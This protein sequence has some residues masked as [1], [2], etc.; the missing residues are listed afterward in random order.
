MSGN[1]GW[2]RLEDVAEKLGPAGVFLIAFSISGRFY[3]DLDTSRPMAEV[4]EFVWGGTSAV[5]AVLFFTRV[6][7]AFPRIPDMES[8]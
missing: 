2:G 4:L 5:S 7:W 6:V 8:R 3:L 1:I